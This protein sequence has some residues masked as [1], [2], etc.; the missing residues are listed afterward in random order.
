MGSVYLATWMAELYGFHV[1]KYTSPMDPMEC[2]LI[3][4]LMR[5]CMV[6]TSHKRRCNPYKYG[7]MKQL[8]I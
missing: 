3:V 6:P 7:Y 5:V 2:L 1:G 8:P 4:Y